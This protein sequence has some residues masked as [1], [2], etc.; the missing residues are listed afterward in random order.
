MKDD[1]A[2]LEHIIEAIDTIEGYI[3]GMDYEAFKNNKMA[4]DA[5]IRELAVVGE[6][7]NNLSQ[8]FVEKNPGLPFRDAI[9]MRNFLIHEYFGIN[10]RL[11]WETAK[12]DLP[13]L[14]KFIEKIS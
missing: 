5:V 6:A 12:D 14:K 4:V 13:E 3:A 11:V 8:E 7:A 2:Y 10:I 1:K 9:D